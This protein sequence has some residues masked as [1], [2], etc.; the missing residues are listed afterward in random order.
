M[1]LSPSIIRYLWSTISL[2]VVRAFSHSRP[3]HYYLC[4]KLQFIRIKSSLNCTWWGT[5]FLIKSFA[6]ILVPCFLVSCYKTKR[7]EKVAGVEFR[8]EESK[9]ESMLRKVRYRD[10]PPPPNER[11]SVRRGGMRLRLCGACFRLWFAKWNRRKRLLTGGAEWAASTS[12]S[13]HQKNK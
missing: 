13:L 11:G 5:D 12:G 9:E 10:V 8:Y 6:L 4:G 7:A 2:V 1:K 3:F